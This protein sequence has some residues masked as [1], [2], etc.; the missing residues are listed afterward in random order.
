MQANEHQKHRQDIGQ[1]LRVIKHPV[2][3][4][5]QSYTHSKI[6]RLMMV[7]VRFLAI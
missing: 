3:A 5:T 2:Y 6:K 4:A 7:V 1:L